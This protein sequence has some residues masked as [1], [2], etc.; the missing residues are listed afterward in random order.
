MPKKQAIY[1]V[2]D[3][4]G[5]IGGTRK[6][7]LAWSRRPSLW[8]PSQLA[9]IRAFRTAKNLGLAGVIYAKGAQ[10]RDT[11]ILKLETQGFTI[12]PE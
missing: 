12:A 3:T 5:A 11:E 2:R 10:E 6:Y 4:G 7:R 8:H 1:T 9:T